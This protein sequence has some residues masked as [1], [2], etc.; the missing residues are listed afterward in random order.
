MNER[1]EIN[2]ASSYCNYNETFTN[3]DQIRQP[4]GL[5]ELLQ[6]FKQNKT[7]LE[8][9]IVLEGGFGTGVY[10]DHIR[11]HIKLIYGVEGSDEGYRQTLQKIGDAKNVRLQ[12]GNILRLPLPDNYFHAYMVNQV[13]HHLDTQPA[14]PN[15]DLFLNESRRVLKPGGVLTIN[16]S[17]PDQLAPDSG[18]YWNYKYIKK[19][20]YALQARYIPIEDII[21]RLET[22]QFTDI[23]TTIPSGKIF[24]EQYYTDPCI[25][26]EPDFR[27][28]DSV[29][30][31]LTHEEIEE[32][33]ALIRAAIEDDSI[34]M[35]MKQAEKNAAKIGE[36]VIISA[37]KPEHGEA[38]ICEK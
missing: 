4:N 12:L 32:S 16:T 13:T 18:V 29:Y 6:I 38:K 34:F 27:K 3:Y 33:N 15:L 21:T 24:H 23:K 11:H 7:P 22:L 30:S 1:N 10:L 2:N 35:E 5:T 26:L 8:E 37:R 17:S 20:V 19:A 25:V 28:G 36:A 14:F 9:Q 31:L